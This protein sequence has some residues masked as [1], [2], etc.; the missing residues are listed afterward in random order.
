MSEAGIEDAIKVSNKAIKIYSEWSE[1]IA[2]LGKN[3]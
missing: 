2:K 1:E 3:T